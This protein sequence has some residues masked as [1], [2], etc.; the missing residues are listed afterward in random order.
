MIP[1]TPVVTGFPTDLLESYPV[2]KE[3]RN[4]IANLP[5]V[6]AFYRCMRAQFT[7]CITA[8]LFWPQQYLVTWLAAPGGAA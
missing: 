5:E 8:A 1:A 3:F 4:S 6:A 2:L 7:S